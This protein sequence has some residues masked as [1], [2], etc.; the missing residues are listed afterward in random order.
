[1]RCPWLLNLPVHAQKDQSG[2]C[3]IFP[4]LH[5]FHGPSQVEISL[6]PPLAEVVAGSTQCMCD[7]YGSVPHAGTG[8]L[9]ECNQVNT[10][11]LPTSLQL[12]PH[13]QSG[14]WYE[15]EGEVGWRGPCHR[16]GCREGLGLM[17]WGW[18]EMGE[19]DQVHGGVW[20]GRR[21]ASSQVKVETVT[22]HVASALQ[23]GCGVRA[24]NP[25][26]AKQGTVNADRPLP[27]R[28]LEPSKF[29]VGQGLW[30]KNIFR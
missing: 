11:A 21:L 12:F 29:Q 3:W 27:W 10:E 14:A 20:A 23:L 24:V 16:G 25:E 28:S 19:G 22:K 7:Q 30:W 13:M 6:Q 8:L 15:G 18:E 1:M 2:S 4:S 26:P 17:L 5:V 9:P